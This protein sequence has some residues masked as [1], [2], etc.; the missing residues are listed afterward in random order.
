MTIAAAVAVAPAAPIAAAP[1]SFAP[2]PLGAVTIVG[3][4]VL[5]AS[6]Y[7]S[8]GH[9]SLSQYVADLGFGPIVARAASGLT[10]GFVPTGYFG[11]PANVTVSSWL[12]EWRAEGW[13]A[14]HVIVNVGAIDSGYCRTNLV[15][16]RDSIQHVID[17]VGPGHHIWWPQITRFYT[18]QAEAETW[19]TALAEFDAARDDFTTW[20]WPSVLVADSFDVYDGVH[21][22]SPAEHARRSERIAQEVYRAW[23]TAHRTGG[24]ASLP[25][26]TSAPARLTPVDP[27]RVLDTRRSQIVEAGRVVEVALAARIPATATS[28]VINVT[29]TQAAADGFLTAYACGGAVPEASNVNFVA[30]QDR[31]AS[32]VVPVG[33]G[34][35]VCVYSSV[36]SHV[37]V[38]LAGYL[39]PGGSLGLVPVDPTRLVDE[40]VPAGTTRLVPVP[41]GAAAVAVGLTADAAD[42]WGYLTVYPCDDEVPEAS[43]VNY[44]PNEAVAGSAYVGT[45]GGAICVYTSARARVIVDLQGRFGSGG[46]SFV[47]ARPTRILDTRNGAGG[48]SPVHGA[49]QVIDISAAPPGA[50]ATTGSLTA[51]G[52]A[53]TVFETAHPCGSAVPNASNVNSQ[54]GR[55]AASG[56]TV[57]VDS[58][59]R[60]CLWSSTVTHTLFD[61]TG[62]WI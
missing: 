53:S 57:R 44:G 3:D 50:V 39:A 9:R 54:P 32:A 15:C 45:G 33:T 49:D 7:P 46:A 1:V 13:D 58:G 22:A 19:N 40:V 4:S 14:P 38:D 61:V 18:H 10:A 28:V 56:V 51:T 6:V 35:S 34:G 21:L 37:V 42:N 29:A 30:G 43:S 52:A 27:V 25:S 36:A 26:A 2:G 5:A 12:A 60:L 16:A 59:G 47:A 11:M 24:D 31:A 62:W 23:A 8:G 48:W 41:G 20:D 17:A 55:A